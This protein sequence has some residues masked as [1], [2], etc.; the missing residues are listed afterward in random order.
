MQKQTLF[1]LTSLSLWTG[2][3]ATMPSVTHANQPV[4]LSK[5]PTNHKLNNLLWEGSKRVK[6]GDIAGALDIYQQAAKLDQDNPR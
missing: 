1:L 6:A 2:I 3:A 5:Q 4:L